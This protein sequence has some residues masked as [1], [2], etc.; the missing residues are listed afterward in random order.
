VQDATYQRLFKDRAA[1]TQAAQNELEP[2]LY[3]IFLLAL[4]FGLRRHEIDL[5]EW[6]SFRWQTGQKR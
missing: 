5:L 6:D 1:L 2:E 4:R 3:K